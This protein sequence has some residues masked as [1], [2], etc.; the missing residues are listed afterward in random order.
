MGASG[1]GEK[2]PPW[3][4]R[5]ARTLFICMVVFAV[6]AAFIGIAFQPLLYVFLGFYC[7]VARLAPSQQ[8]SRSRVSTKREL[9]RRLPDGSPA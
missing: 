2:E 6:G 7:S 1:A 8:I 3:H 4:A 5:F 9:F